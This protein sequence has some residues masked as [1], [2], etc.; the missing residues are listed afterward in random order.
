MNPVW[1][2]TLVLAALVW[3]SWDDTRARPVEVDLPSAEQDLALK[4]SQPRVRQFD[5]NGDL[6]ST[7]AA[8]EALDYGNAKPGQVITPALSWPQSGWNAKSDRG[9]TTA[10]RTLLLGN[11]VATHPG[12]SRRVD[13]DQ[14]EY[15]GAVMTARGDAT[16][17]SPDFTATAGQ[18]R[19]Q[20]DIDR[21]ELTTQVTTTLWPVR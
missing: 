20:T 7:M 4:V 13:A 6:K 17:R 16:I 21:I 19:I 5:V 18:V 12:E 10:E 9:E 3:V 15:Q 1:V 11:A 8:P 2:A 14:I